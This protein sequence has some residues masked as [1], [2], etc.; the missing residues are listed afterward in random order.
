MQF[1]SCQRNV[2]DPNFVALSHVQLVIYQTHSTNSMS[3]KAPQPNPSET[4]GGKI[5]H[6]RTHNLMNG[7]GGQL[8]NAMIFGFGST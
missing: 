8:K 3:E 2:L 7:V 4:E 6:A 5:H 1:I